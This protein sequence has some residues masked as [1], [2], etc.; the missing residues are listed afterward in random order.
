MQYT[1]MAIKLT[2]IT[3]ACKIIPIV[4]F[5]KILIFRERLFDFYGGGGGGG[6]EDYVGPGI[7]FRLKLIFFFECCL[8]LDIF[9]LM[10]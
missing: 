3:K 9:F 2:N 1:P 7:F 8:I 5:E 6:Q 4:Y 10:R